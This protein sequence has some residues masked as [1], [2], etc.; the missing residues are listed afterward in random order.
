MALNKELRQTLHSQRRELFRQAAKT[1]EDL[2]WLETDVERELEE[3]G[4][5]EK[6]I[7]FL[8]RMDTRLKAEIEAIDR[9][10]VKIETGEYGRCEECH[11]SIAQSRLQALPATPLC[12]SCAQAKE[13]EESLRR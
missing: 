5:D 10:L 2:L 13:A 11:Q 1:E 9:A 6:M 3:R 12:L 8:D 4:Q 7:Q